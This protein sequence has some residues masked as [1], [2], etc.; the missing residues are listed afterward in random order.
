[1]RDQQLRIARRVAGVQANQLISLTAGSDD[2]VGHA[3]QIL[4]RITAQILQFESKSAEV[5]QPLNG[6]RFENSHQAARHSKQFRRQRGIDFRRRMAV[7]LFLTQIDRLERNKDYP[8]IGGAAPAETKSHDGKC[9]D[10][11]HRSG[12]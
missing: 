5:T 7:A 2:L 3:V 8:V 1:M 9:P 11:R 12:G 10:R 6:R 4:Q